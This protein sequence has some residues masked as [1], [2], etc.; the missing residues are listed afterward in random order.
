MRDQRIARRYA[1]ALI[2][3]SDSVEEMEALGKE[4]DQV[5]QT[6]YQ[7]EGLLQVYTGVQFAHVEKKRVITEIF[8]DQVR[9]EILNFLLLLV[10]KMRSAYLADITAAYRVLVDEAKGV[11]DATVYSAF[12]LED[13]DVE[14]IAQAL[15]DA[16]GKTIRLKAEVDESLLAGL[17]VRYGDYVIDGSAQA[18][19]EGLRQTLTHH[20][21][22]AEVNDR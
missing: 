17:R 7:H 12:P 3:L 10:D 6:I 13:G 18:Q 21:M 11:K 20:S 1:H 2:D 4:L 22:S 19:L 14:R 16:L 9:P 8:K 5:T 15:S